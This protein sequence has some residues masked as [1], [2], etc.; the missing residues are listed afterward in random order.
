MTDR[1]VAIRLTI[2]GR[3]DIT[4]T[5]NDITREGRQAFE[6]VAAGTDGA[7]AAAGRLQE[8]YKA[9]AQQAQA[10]AQQAASQDWFGKNLGI[11][12]GAGSAAS[13]AA[14]F[15]AQAAKAREATAAEAALAAEAQ[16][17]INTINPL[18]AAEATM[19]AQIE[20]ANVLFNAQKIT[21]QQL[22]QTILYAKNNFEQA[23]NQQALFG[24]Q[25]KLTA[26][27]MQNLGFQIND[28]V[29]GLAS[30]QGVFRV[31]IQQG[32]Q[33]A[34]IFGPGVGVG[35]VFSAIGK[36]IMSVIGPVTISI[37]ALGGA[38]VLVG[39]AFMHWA[40]TS[41]EVNRALIGSGAAAGVTAGEIEK[42]AKASAEASQAGIGAARDIELSF[43]RTGIVG[44]DVLQRLTT[45][46]V[47]FSRATGAS[48]DDARKAMTDAFSDPMKGA[49]DL[50]KQLGF[51]DQSTLSLI[52]SLQR[53][54]QLQEAQLLLYGATRDKIEAMAAAQST[55]TKAWNDTWAAADN[56][57]DRAGKGFAAY[58]DNVHAV[59]QALASLKLP[60]WMGALQSLL[61]GGDKPSGAPPDR[62]LAQ[63]FTDII[64]SRESL[65]IG[66]LNSQYQ[67]AIEQHKAYGDA[68]ARITQF[69]N[70][71]GWEKAMG[72]GNVAETLDL[73]ARLHEADTTFLTDQEKAAA[74]AD[75]AHRRATATTSDL[76]AQIAYDES[77]INS[78]GTLATHTQR[79]AA[80]ELAAS[81]ARMTGASSAARHSDAIAKETAILTLSAKASLDT[82]D[83]YL[84]SSLAGEQNEATRKAISE[85]VRHGV[86][87]DLRSQQVMREN[88]ADQLASGAKATAVMRDDAAAR[89]IINAQVIAGLL[90]VSQMND[91]IK[92]ENELR[93]DTIALAYAQEKGDAALTAK[94]LAQ[95]AARKAAFASN[96]GATQESGALADQRTN[97]NAVAL[98]QT[99]INLSGISIAQREHIVALQ[100]AEQD[101]LAKYPNL[102]EAE[103][104]ALVLQTV[105]ISDMTHTLAM[106]DA[107]VS[108]ITNAIGSQLD[109][110]GAGLAQG[111]L[112]WGSWAMS[113]LAAINQVILQLALINPIKN[114]LTG[115][116]DYPTVGGLGGFLQSLFGSGSS[117]TEA[118]ASVDFSAIADSM[119]TLH[120]GG[121]VG[122]D[123]TPRVLS[124]KYLVG[125]IPRYHNG[126]ASD[127]RLSILQTGEQ[128]LSRAQVRRNQQQP[129]MNFYQTIQS[130]N[131]Q[132]YRAGRA[133]MAADGLALVRQARRSR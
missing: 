11:S 106:S 113:A 97:Q 122:V 98:L 25:S 27:A 130:P 38:A 70:T 65:A 110:I 89:A 107:A 36:S 7:S 4:R 85:A 42:I 117:L 19:N 126:L 55:F 63:G 95:I 99:Q 91:A 87:Q 123:G 84:K 12:G 125:D 51:L 105:A 59:N 74:L 5:W 48:M 39:S 112:D 43:I 66:K 82:A 92:L 6:Q 17:L 119:M 31:A 3:E 100:K 109:A 1:S 86:D 41:L 62:G 121:I 68:L 132:A 10:S 129:Q 73:K 54:G 71:P 35:A 52:T 2:A 108:A 72:V 22:A 83:A 118:G 80:A 13:S 115:G 50:N 75:I 34:Q 127:E 40:D 131:P 24:S 16:H 111:K 77:L 56:F 116:S 44:G 103:R 128:V 120:G 47:E 46:T 96:L 78:A 53:Q 57:F 133:Q 29:V 18:A 93:Q 76:K 58:I 33:I 94:I 15:E 9:L 28:V 64:L 37:A 101:V 81:S 124:S 114:A 49:E 30:G 32:A 102:S 69:T 14:V 61:P 88:I 21:A 104:R 26:F 45:L 8:R 20:R 90:P 23:R 67:T 79:L 60:G